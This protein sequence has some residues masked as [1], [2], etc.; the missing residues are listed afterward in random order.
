MVE[1]DGKDSPIA[2]NIKN[3]KIGKNE[4]DAIA[5][6]ACWLIVKLILA[7]VAKSFGPSL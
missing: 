3:L 6:L 4:N 1:G 7:V 5:S 2:E